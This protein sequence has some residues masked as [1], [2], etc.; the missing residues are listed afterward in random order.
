MEPLHPGDPRRI[1]PYELEARLG[2]GGMGQV[3]LGESPG[4]RR[5][6][7]KVVRAE[8]AEDERFRRRFARE[9]EAARRVGGFHTAQVVDADP[10]AESPWLVTAFIPG[11]SLRE[12]VAERGPL[13]PDAVRAL[14]AGLAEGLAAIHACGLVHRDLKPGNVIMAADGPRIIDFGIA[15]AADATVLTSHNVVVGTYAYMS[16]EQVLGDVPGPPGDVFSL[17]CVLAY[18]ATGGGPFDATSIPA[19]VHRVLHEEPDL[20][21]LPEDLRNLIAACLAKEPERRPTLDALIS[22]PHSIEAPAPHPASS[23]DDAVSTHAN[24]TR[25]A[26]REQDA[27]AV[28]PAGPAP[29][30]RRAL[31]IGGGV[32]AAAATAGVPAALFLTRGDGTGRAAP[33]APAPR[34][35][36]LVSPSGS[37]TVSD[38]KSLSEVAV[39]AD[40]RTIAAGGLDS[41]ITLWDVATGRVLRTIKKTGWVSA[42]AF[43]PDGRSLASSCSTPGLLLIWDAATGRLKVNVRSGEFGLNSLAY[44]PDGRTIAGANPDA[45]LFDSD[46]GRRLASYDLRHSG[47]NA[48]DCSP[49]GRLVAAGVDGYYRKPPGNTVQLLDGRTLRKRGQLVGHTANLTGV[50]F[51]SDGRLL[52][53]S[54]A[55]KTVRI[56]DVATRRAV[57]V[58]KAGEAT[59]RDTKF[60]P[61]GSSV[62]AACSDRTIR[63]WNA[64]T[65]VLTS[66]LVG[67]A[68]PVERMVLTPDGRTVAGVGGTKADNTVTLWKV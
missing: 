36:G 8:Y 68:Q 35:K 18:A 41:T 20:S 23:P 30:G 29:V 49:D 52:A 60:S 26:T 21:A 6:A 31:L 38:V 28:A 11:P 44:S 33:P 5:V 58:I 39:T 43:S 66:T 22:T 34:P 45:Q 56:W 25:V 59:V 61:D 17:G 67:H 2:A 64:A 24:A 51:S 65:G 3:F 1:G 48:I 42:L 55:D 13:D 47:V 15:L 14:A 53:S 37:L 54:A 10:E 12:V 4:G 32:V 16:P 9:V 62:L 7:V 27:P 57:R 46:S 50:A 63:I 19:I 40:G